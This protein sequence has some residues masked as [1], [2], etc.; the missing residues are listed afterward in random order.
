[1]LGAVKVSVEPFAKALANAADNVI[2]VPVFEATTVL[3]GIAPTTLDVTVYPLAKLP[4]A[5]FI[6]ITV[7][8]CGSKAV[9]VVV[10]VPKLKSDFGLTATL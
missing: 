5:V 6:A 7:S 2:V 9:V 1:M 10:A 4:V 8:P 3:A